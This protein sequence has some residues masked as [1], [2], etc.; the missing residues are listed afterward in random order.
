MS[1]PLTY[2]PNVARTAASQDTPARSASHDPERALVLTVDRLIA[3]LAEEE[4]HIERR[5]ATEL[6]ALI[7]RK[8]H[9]AVELARIS[10]A[11]QGA[12]L[13]QIARDKL[14][15]VKT[16]IG[17]NRDT[18]RRHVEAVRSVHNLIDQVVAEAESDGTYSLTDLAGRPSP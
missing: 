14:A 5:D 18:L 3:T 7:A 16:A 4:G 6:D 15:A 9:L 2:G 13:S 8:S 17:A 10:L 12:Q 11:L 1:Q